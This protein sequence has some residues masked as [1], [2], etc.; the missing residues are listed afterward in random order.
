MSSRRDQV[1][2]FYCRTRYPSLWRT[3]VISQSQSGA[4]QS[5]VGGKLEKQLQSLEDYGNYVIVVGLYRSYFV[6]VGT[7]MPCDEVRKL[8]EV[9]DGEALWWGWG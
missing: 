3:T 6:S 5:P 7:L 9:V 8:S 1:N 2:G 4:W